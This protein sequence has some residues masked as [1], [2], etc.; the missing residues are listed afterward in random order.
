MSQWSPVGQRLLDDLTR[1]GVASGDVVMVH[2]S[3]RRVGAGPDSAGALIEALDRAVAPGGSWM[4][5]LGAR[6]DWAWVNERPEHEREALLSDADA[7]DALATP[8]EPD[9]G[10]LAEVM[11]TTPGTVVSDH[12]EGR[13]AARGAAPDALLADVPWH[14]YYGPG[15]PLAR[16]LEM[17]GKVLRLGADPDT[18]TLLHHSEYL[19]DVPGARR[20]RRCR[21]VRRSDGDHIVW[22]ECLDDS[23]GIVETE[24]EDYFITV[25]REYLATGRARRDTVG[26]ATSELIDARDLADFGAQW[27][28]A[29]LTR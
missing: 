6:D 27:I 5:V 15:S 9:V 23:E 7:F 19:A 28:R 18:V 25:L 29:N 3:L 22:I 17:Q 21:K 11:R 13:F 1:L 16:L 12:P 14:D 10:M 8:A 4:M 24:G 20:V 2:A 26:A